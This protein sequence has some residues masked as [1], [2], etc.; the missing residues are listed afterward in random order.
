VGAAKAPENQARAAGENRS[1]PVGIG[2]SL[3]PRVRRS[4]PEVL[5]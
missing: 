1:R 4:K 3:L 5:Q 2:F